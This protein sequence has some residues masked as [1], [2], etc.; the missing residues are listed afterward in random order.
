MTTTTKINEY[1][2]GG[3]CVRMTKEMAERWNAGDWTD[4]DDLAARVIMADQYEQRSSLRDGE[5]VMHSPRLVKACESITMKEAFERGLHDKFMEGMPAS[6][7][8]ENV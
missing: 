6:L 7:T 8:R 2:I 3:V 4:A 1:E 5:V